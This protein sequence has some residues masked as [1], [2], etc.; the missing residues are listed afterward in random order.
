M[1]ARDGAGADHAVGLEAVPPLEALHRLDDRRRIDGAAVDGSCGRA[2]EIAER[3]QPRSQLR[4]PSQAL[5][6]STL[7]CPFGQRR[8]RLRLPSSWPSALYRASVLR[9]RA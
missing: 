6:G 1:S 7:V 8:H 4:R 2:R 3:A 5:P 9:A